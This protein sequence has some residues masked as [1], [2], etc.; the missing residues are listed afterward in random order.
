MP[1]HFLLTNAASGWLGVVNFDFL[2]IAVAGVRSAI[3]WLFVTLASVD[4]FLCPFIGGTA[5]RRVVGPHFC[6]LAACFEMFGNG[7]AG[8]EKGG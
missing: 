5:C 2:G 6:F 4:Y 8:Y 3:C 1:V 7:P